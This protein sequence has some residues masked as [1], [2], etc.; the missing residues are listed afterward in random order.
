MRGAAKSGV[1]T[2][3]GLLDTVLAAAGLYFVVRFILKWRRKAQ[4]PSMVDPARRLMTSLRI[5]PPVLLVALVTVNVLAVAIWRLVAAIT[6]IAIDALA[7]IAAGV[8]VLVVWERAERLR[9]TTGYVI[10]ELE[11]PAAPRQVKSA[12]RKIF[13]S[14]RSIRAGR[15]TS[16]ACSVTWS[17]MNWSMRQL[18]GRCSAP[19]C[20]RQ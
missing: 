13:R 10:S 19:S 9:R 17:S 18:N 1:P 20:R 2:G 6:L 4:H 5:V 8:G 11:Y 15:A 3:G 12:M 14:A 7:L 16:T